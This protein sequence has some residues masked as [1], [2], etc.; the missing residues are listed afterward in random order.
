VKTWKRRE[1]QVAEFFGTNRTPLSGGNSG[2]TRADTLHPRLF[3]E[4][5]HRAK[6]SV[7]TLWDKV[8]KLARK[9]GKTPVLTLT[10]QNRAG[11]WLVIYCD[12]LP[13]VAGAIVSNE[14]AQN[15]L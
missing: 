5:K 15:A 8:K 9:E 12:D 10:Q 3:I 4:Q 13:T 2:G 6:H 14:A 7:I 11:F 1:K